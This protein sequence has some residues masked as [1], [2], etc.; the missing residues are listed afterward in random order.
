MFPS[1]FGHTQV[2]ASVILSLEESSCMSD[3]VIHRLTPSQE[4]LPRR[5]HQPAGEL[6][7]ISQVREQFG[8]EQGANS[9]APE[10]PL[11]LKVEIKASRVLQPARLVSGL[12]ILLALLLVGETFLMVKGHGLS[13]A[14]LL[15][16]DQAL[17]EAIIVQ[18]GDDLEPLPIAPPLP[19]AM[20]SPPGIASPSPQS[21]IVPPSPE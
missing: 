20:S 8:A 15:Q 14:N 21:D 12:I 2:S 10:I 19:G 6:D 11:D 13:V 4:E 17:E 18:L 5:S 1:D 7:V 16:N 9:Q 3:N